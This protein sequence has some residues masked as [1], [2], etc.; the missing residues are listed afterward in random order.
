MQNVL[1]CMQLKSLIRVT[2]NFICRIT[3]KSSLVLDLLKLEITLSLGYCA[4][5]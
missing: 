3:F 5:Y 1:D 4:S 2:L